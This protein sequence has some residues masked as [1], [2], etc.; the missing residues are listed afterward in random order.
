MSSDHEVPLRSSTRPSIDR[1]IYTRIT[2]MAV[3]IV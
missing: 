3:L 2:V 1:V